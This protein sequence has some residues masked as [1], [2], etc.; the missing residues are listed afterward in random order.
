MS[1]SISPDSPLG[2]PQTPE[3]TAQFYHILQQRIQQIRLKRG[4]LNL[5][6]RPWPADGIGA[7]DPTTDLPLELPAVRS[8]DIR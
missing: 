1:L 5:L 6:D 2:E 8:R 7:Q 4:L 3:Q